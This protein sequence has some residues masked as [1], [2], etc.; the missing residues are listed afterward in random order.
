M[1]KPHFT[2]SQTKKVYVKIPG[3]YLIIEPK[4]VESD[5]PGVLIGLS[6]NGVDYDQ[7][8]LIACV[9]YVTPDSEIAV[10]TY[11]KGQ[12]EPTA[13]MMFE[14]GRNKLA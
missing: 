6:R 11:M 14:D 5:Y 8:N 9:E 2:G 13:I 1:N 4:G 12:E 3:G 7:D 10:E